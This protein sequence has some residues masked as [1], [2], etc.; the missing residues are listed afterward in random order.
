MLTKQ[1]LVDAVNT[2]PEQFSVDELIEYALL[3]KKYKRG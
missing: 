3:S 1:T 2:F